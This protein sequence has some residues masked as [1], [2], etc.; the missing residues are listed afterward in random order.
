ML[1]RWS[2][3]LGVLTTAVLITACGDGS[4]TSSTTLT[5]PSSVPASTVPTQPVTTVPPTTVRPTTAPPTTA[6][7]SAALG[8][9]FSA[10]VGEPV[11]ITGAGLSVT[12]SKVVS[13]N[14]CPIGSQCI[15]AGDASITVAMSKA[16]T[17]PGSLTLSTDAPKSARY[18]KYTVELVRLGRGS[19]PTAGLKVS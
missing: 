8:E 1:H 10:R 3:A 18:G 7:R 17:A 19:A 12:F 16:G 15:Q 5:A 14:R 6:A 2:A 11:L 4:A 13:D 9:T